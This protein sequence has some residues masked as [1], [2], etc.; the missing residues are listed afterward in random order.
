LYFDYGKQ[1]RISKVSKVLIRGAARLAIYWRFLILWAIANSVSYAGGGII[2]AFVTDYIRGNL[3]VFLSFA[4]MSMAIALG[5]W[6]VIRKRIKGLIWLWTTWLGG[7]FGGFISSWTSF[8]LAF[9]YGDAVDLLVVY[10]CLRGF[11]TGLCQWFALK[12]LYHKKSQW[13][14]VITTASWYLSIISGS[15]L[16]EKLPSFRYFTTLAIGASYG[17]LTGLALCNFYFIFSDAASP[18]R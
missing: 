17:I 16:I 11:T 4:V 9:T 3:G 10:A 1:P 8:E 2:S 6:L 18:R 14:I 5:Q 12:K 7:T 13:W 15:M